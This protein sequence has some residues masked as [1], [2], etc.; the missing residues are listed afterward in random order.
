[1]ATSTNI[2]VS[3]SKKYETATIDGKQVKNLVN[4]P[5]IDGVVPYSLPETLD[6]AKTMFG[7]AIALSLLNQKVT[8]FVQDTWR[9][10]VASGTD[11]AKATE[12]ASAAKPG[13]P[14]PRAPID[15][16]AAASAAMAGM[17]PEERKAFIA[18]LAQLAKGMA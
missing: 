4:I 17:S 10:A 1:M 6:E 7:E 5:K 11:V 14:T 16:K 13:M 15:P 2:A 18:S 3:C 9:R 12:L 8:I